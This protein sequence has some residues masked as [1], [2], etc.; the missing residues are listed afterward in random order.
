M[1]TPLFRRPLG[2]AL[3]AMALAYGCG[4][5][6]TLPDDGSPAALEAFR[7]NGQEGTVGTL[8]PAPLVARLTD[9]GGAPVP[10]ASVA[11]RFPSNVPGAEIEPEVRET[12]EKGE[13]SVRVRLGTIA[14]PQTIEASLDPPSSNLRATFTLTAVAQ[15]EDGDG[16]DDSDGD[17]GRGKGRGRGG[18]GDDDD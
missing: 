1:R 16:D 6:L 9:A 12:D 18:G 4:D 17:R 2:L 10:G 3:G 8:L 14:G 7:G 5:D 13:A 11:F 15:E